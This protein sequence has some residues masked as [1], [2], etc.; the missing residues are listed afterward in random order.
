RHTRFSRDWSSDVCSSDLKDTV[1]I[2]P[3][4]GNTGIALA[5][6]AAAKGYKVILVMP[7]TMSIER[8]NLLMAYGAELVLT[9]GPEGMRACIARSEERRVGKGC[10]VVGS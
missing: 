10:G 6:V 8:R 1:I 7:D 4:S 9:P 2:E 3:T 5:C